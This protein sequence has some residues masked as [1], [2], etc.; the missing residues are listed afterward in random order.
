MQNIIFEDVAQELID[1]EF[2]VEQEYDGM[3]AVDGFSD[4]FEYSNGCKS[5]QPDFI[6]QG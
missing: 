2:L 4:P 6:V 5:A 3:E 1:N